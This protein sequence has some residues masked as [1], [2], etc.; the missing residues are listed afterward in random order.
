MRFADLIQPSC[1]LFLD[2]D[3][4]LVDIAPRPEDVRVPPG[5]VDTLAELRHGLGGALALVSGR[6]IAQ[7]DAF[8]APLR[9]PAA[10]EHGGERRDSL[11]GL[12]LH[13]PAPLDRVL[14]A[15]AGLADQHPA[16]RVETKRAA[17]ALHYRQAPQLEAICLAAMQAAV[18]ASPGLVL[19]RGKR[20]AEAKPAGVGK[21]QAIEAFLSEPDFRG[22]LPLFVGD[23]ITDE[24]GFTVVQGHGGIGVKVGDGSTT[25]F[26]RLASP[27]ALR[28]ELQAAAGR[29]GPGPRP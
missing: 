15:A 18:D 12:S 10:G 1:A 6:P 19:L 28:R 26:Q 3:G 2:F 4:T 16:L 25:A 20:V 8:L 9:L 11:G 5:L 14:Q 23:D 7:L 22:R 24:V 21:G 29:L 27:A 17:V 13:P